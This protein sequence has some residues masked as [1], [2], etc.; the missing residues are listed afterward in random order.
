MDKNSGE[1]LWTSNLPVRNIH[2]GQWSAPAV[3]LLEVCRKVVFCGGDVL[4]L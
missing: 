2:H 1:V 3:G 4:G